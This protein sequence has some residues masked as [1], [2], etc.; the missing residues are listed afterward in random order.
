M[1]SSNTGSPALA[2]AVL[3]SALFAKRS[4]LD[5]ATTQ[6]AAFPFGKVGPRVDRAPVV[7]HQ[8]VAQL[9]DV[10]KDEFRPLADF[11]ELLEDRIALVRVE[12]F[13]AGGHEPV[14]EQRLAAS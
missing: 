7:P 14:H 12:P 2:M 9:P 6:E 10:L 4:A 8:E 11:I 1:N 3:R 13:D 5:R